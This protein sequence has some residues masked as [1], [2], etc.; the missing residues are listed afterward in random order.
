MFGR[1]VDLARR[2]NGR[3]T[4]KWFDRRTCLQHNCRSGGET[5]VMAFVMFFATYNELKYVIEMFDW[6]LVLFSSTVYKTQ[7]KEV[8]LFIIRNRT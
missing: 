4:G 6:Q 7:I 1:T 3:S 8:L 2:L 5:D